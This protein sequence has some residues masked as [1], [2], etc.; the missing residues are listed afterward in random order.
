MNQITFKQDKTISGNGTHLVEYLDGHTIAELCKKFPDA[1]IDN[2]VYDDGKGYT[3]DELAFVSS[4]GTPFKVYSRWGACRIGSWSE[5]KEE[6]AAFVA[7]I[8]Q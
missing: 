6:I 4:L 5:N 7:Y 3:E 2:P 1:V 8:N